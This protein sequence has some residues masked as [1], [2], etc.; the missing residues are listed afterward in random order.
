MTFD[1][2]MAQLSK[3][4]AELGIRETTGYCA[5]AEL[6]EYEWDE[7]CDMAIDLIKKLGG[8]K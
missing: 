2:I 8:A 7:L 1:E 5:Y 6:S 3:I 4:V